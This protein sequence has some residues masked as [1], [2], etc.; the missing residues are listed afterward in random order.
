MGEKQIFIR[1]SVSIF[2]LVVDETV[3][4][5]IS[6]AIDISRKRYALR[7]HDLSEDP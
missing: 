7:E 6:Y 3:I 5:A 1:G 4:K 2:H